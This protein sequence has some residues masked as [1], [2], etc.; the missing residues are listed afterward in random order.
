MESFRPVIVMCAR[1]LR[2]YSVVVAERAGILARSACEGGI[3]LWVNVGER[4][5]FTRER[6]PVR[7]ALIWPRGSKAAVHGNDRGA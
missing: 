2:S 6:K 5:Q 1:G 3:A 7:G 4:G